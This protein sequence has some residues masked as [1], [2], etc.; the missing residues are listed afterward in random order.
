MARPMTAEA[1][2]LRNEVV[3]AVQAEL[4]QGRTPDR[5]AV[6]KRF[7]DRGAMSTLLRWIDGALAGEVHHNPAASCSESYGDDAAA[8]SDV[9]PSSGEA[10]AASCG[11]GA[12][13]IPRSGEALPGS[14]GEAPTVTDPGCGDAPIEP[15]APASMPP[16][17]AIS[18]GVHDVNTLFADWPPALVARLDQWRRFQY[19]RPSRSEAIVILVRHALGLPG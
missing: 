6:A 16:A 13:P 5:L 15:V 8:C 12:A 9:A 3:A 14:S 2:A 11:D 10:S 19:D 4:D 17:N 18:K 1:A 7:L